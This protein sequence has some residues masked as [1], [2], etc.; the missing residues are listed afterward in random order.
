MINVCSLAQQADCHLIEFSDGK[1]VLVDVADAVD[2]PGA[3]MRYLRGRSI[4]RIDLVVI[5]HFHKDHYDRLRDL[6]RS[7][8][9]V[10]RVAV[11]VPDKTIANTEQPW[12]YDGQDVKDL[13]RFL[14]DN[15]VPYFTPR[16]GERLVAVPVPGTSKQPVF[17]TLDVVAIYDGFHTPIGK[18]DVNDTSIILR[19]SHG[20]TRALLTGDL[21]FRLGMYL[22]H[23][24][25]DLSADILKLPHHGTEGAAPD[26]FFERV[27]PK[28][29][30][31][32]SPRALWWSMRSK[33]IRTFMADHRIPA[34]ISGIN[35]DVTVHMTEDRFWI[36]TQR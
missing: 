26:E 20:G 21:N 3:A 35:G 11:N 15:G 32:P 29:A 12:G 19:L 16:M 27:N 28:A 13:L 24:Q 31:V 34:Y 30:L 1:T 6:V 4:H 10:E 9:R 17:A 23:S 33:R 18:T 36:Q 7:G 8:I 2:T 25:L 22:A 5:S 14:T